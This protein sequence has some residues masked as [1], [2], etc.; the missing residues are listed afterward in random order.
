VYPVSETGT[1]TAN[2]A[3][4]QSAIDTL[5]TTATANTV[6]QVPNTF[7]M[8][9]QLTFRNQS[10]EYWIGF[11]RTDM[12][13][14]PA[15]S[16]GT[17][18]GSYVNRV[19]F[20]DHGSVL[21]TF[22]Q[23]GNGDPHIVFDTGAHHYFFDGIYFTN[24]NGY[25][26][27]A[28]VVRFDSVSYDTTIH[29]IVFAHWLADGDG[30]F[31]WQR[32]FRVCGTNI[33]IID[34]AIRNTGYNESQAVWMIGSC[35][36]IRIHNNDLRDMC[37]NANEVIMSGGASDTGMTYNV[38][39]TGNYIANRG[40]AK[41]GIEIK[42]GVR[43]AIAG[44]IFGTNTSGNPQNGQITIKLTEQGGSV[45]LTTDTHDVTVL[46]NLIPEGPG[47]VVI[48]GM[49]LSPGNTNTTR[50]VAVRNTLVYGLGLNGLGMPMRMLST[51]MHDI[52]IKYCTLIGSK[53]IDSSY[54][55][56]L[57]FEDSSDDDAVK[58]YNIEITTNVMV[59]GYQNPNMV[60]CV[61]GPYAGQVN[62]NALALLLKT[63]STGGNLVATTYLSTTQIGG[64]C[65]D[66]AA[67]KFV[68]YAAD[69]YQLASDSPGYHA[70]PALKDAGYD[71]ALLDTVIARVLP[72]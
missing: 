10:H 3:A 41:A 37:G 23:G 31:K 27:L 22:E 51:T 19:T 59:G 58:A 30:V 50:Y 39:I 11:Q 71:K 68:N 56:A 63:S 44:N 67:M 62:D 42:K 48:T 2:C 57:R 43:V 6:I 16:P 13:A 53:V 7:N 38:E 60:T 24:P 8:Q 40:N 15:C 33:G 46:S 1:S 66:V 54:I 28:G 69:Q 17:A 64:G 12:S 25:E 49:E 29:N 9:G 72:T 34:G 61:D 65:A 21:P 47:G 55:P 20:A 14:I 35:N 18:S 32:V 26:S 45:D 36:G 52:S 70:T 5:A 4:V